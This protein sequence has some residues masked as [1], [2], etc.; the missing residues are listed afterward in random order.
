MKIARFFMFFVCLVSLFHFSGCQKPGNPDGRLDVSG[1][2][3]LNGG[4]FKGASMCTI[5]FTPVDSSDQETLSTT[6]NA[7]SGKYLLTMQD[8]LKPGKYKVRLYATAVYDRKTKGP[9]GPATL[10]SDVYHIV[11][12]PPKFNKDSTIEFEVVSGKKNVFDY[13]IKDELIFEEADNGDKK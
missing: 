2:I 5:T 8:A 10:D 11:L 1:K 6:F 13:D 9:V 12:I 4:P 7:D 3:T